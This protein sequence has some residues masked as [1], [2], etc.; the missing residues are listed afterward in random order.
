[1]L[2]DGGPSRERPG[3]RRHSTDR[4][5]HDDRSRAEAPVRHL[6]EKTAKAVEETKELGRGLVKR[7]RAG[8][9]RTGKNSLV[10]E[11]KKL[12]D[13]YFLANISIIVYIL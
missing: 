11:D 1:M 9:A 6:A 10:A 13:K 8:P 12:A 2:L 4:M 5:G 7:L 3:H